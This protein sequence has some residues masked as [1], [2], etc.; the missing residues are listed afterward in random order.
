MEQKLERLRQCID[1][2]KSKG[3]IHKQQD[4]ADK[5]GIHKTTLSDALKGR[6][7]YF[8]DGFLRRFGAAYADYVNARWLLDGSGSMERVDPRDFRPDIPLRVAAGPTGT[9]LGSA[10]EGECELRPVVAPFPWYDF[11]ITVAGDSMLP[12]LNDGDTVACAWLSDLS[13]LRDGSIC[14]LDTDE[15]A[16]I[17]RVEVVRLRH[18]SLSSDPDEPLMLRCSSLNPAYLP[19]LLPASSVRRIARAVGV[20]ALL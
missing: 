20:Y 18:G 19:F 7:R 5:L 14:V 13:Q 10:L 1:Y 9:Q 12:R 11:T 16:V 17:K 3:Q 6:P 15:G 2:L 8:T 4:I